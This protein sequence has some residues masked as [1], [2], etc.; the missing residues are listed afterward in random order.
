[1]WALVTAVAGVCCRS[2]SAADG[3]NKFEFNEDC[4]LDL[5]IQKDSPGKAKE[6]NWLPSPAGEFMLILRL[7]WP[8]PVGILDGSWQAPGV[9]RV[10]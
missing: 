9:K 3:H 5:F 6:A 7:C 8:R 10:D 4:S 1:M 2:A